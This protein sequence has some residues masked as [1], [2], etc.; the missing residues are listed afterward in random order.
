M[1]L[2]ELNK[3]L[4]E[5]QMNLIQE[6]YDSRFTQLADMLDEKLGSTEK[7]NKNELE[8][9]IIPMLKRGK[10]TLNEIDSILNE[11]CSVIIT[12][13]VASGRIQ[14]ERIVDVD[15]PNSKGQTFYFLEDE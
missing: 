2:R 14:S 8:K 5:K 3:D 6:I 10:F 1:Q 9:R 15:H 4:I 12:K 11:S 13:L 7:I